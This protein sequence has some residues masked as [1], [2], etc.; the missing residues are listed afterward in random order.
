MRRLGL[1]YRFNLLYFW[2]TLLDER[3]NTV[4]EGHRCHRATCTMP[5]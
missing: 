3:F 5:S 1:L 4:F 2:D